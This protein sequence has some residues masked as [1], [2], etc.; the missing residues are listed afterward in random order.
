MAMGKF[1]QIPR[2]VAA[3]RD[4]TGNAKVVYAAIVD[5][6]G[7]NGHGW[8]G[9]RALANEI[10]ANRDTVV[11]CVRQL[12]QAGLLLVE[13]GGL[14]KVNH[15]RVAEV[16]EKPGHFPPPEVSEKISQVSEF[17]D[18]ENPAQSVRKT[19]PQVSEKPGAN[20]THNQT[21]EPDPTKPPAAKPPRVYARNLHAD[22]FKEAFDTV[23][24]QHYAFSTADFVQLAG[25]TKEY[26]NVTPAE[27]AEVAK[28]CWALG[29]YCP[30]AAL[31]IKGLCADWARCAFKAKEAKNGQSANPSQNRPGAY[32]GYS[33]PPGKK[34]HSTKMPSLL[35]PE[36]DKPP[37]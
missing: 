22:A 7:K 3:R 8:P 2:S 35:M 5:H 31:T 6:I 25:W 1:Y 28:G 26:P 23:H 34:Y 15:Y 19:R 32:G 14:G 9:E 10:G 16:S 36:P 13:R 21:K 4:L 20:Q 18:T 37:A 17:S 29:T 33:S 12:E 24:P 11:S 27:F 30:G